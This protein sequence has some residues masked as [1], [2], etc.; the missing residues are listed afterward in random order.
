[1]S[2]TRA[3]G[4]PAWA[5]TAA[6]IT[7]TAT[8]D[9]GT[10]EGAG[11]RAALAT[12]GPSPTSMCAWSTT[13]TVPRP[14]T[15]GDRAASASMAAM[16][17]R[18]RSPRPPSGSFNSVNMLRPWQT[19]WRM[20]LPHAGCRRNVR[21]GRRGMQGKSVLKGAHRWRPRLDLPSLL[22]PG[23]SRFARRR[24]CA[25]CR[26]RQFDERHRQRKFLRKSLP[27]PLPPLPHTD[28]HL[29]LHP[30]LHKCRNT[31]SGSLLP[32]CTPT[33]RSV[34]PQA[35]ALSPSPKGPRGLRNSR[36]S[37]KART[38]KSGERSAG[39]ACSLPHGRMAS[40]RA[41]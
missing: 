12:T 38:A 8:P 41:S 6:S 2:G 29:A 33:R 10:R 19:N 18:R 34:R 7:A 36:S 13:S 40:S 21:P 4:Q 11:I 1:M 26:A 31:R 28:L 35:S 16:A 32:R 20:R 27:L 22:R 30:A 15:P 17:V 9:R 3:I 25:P 14:R 23:W 24:S 5:T 39:L 37:M